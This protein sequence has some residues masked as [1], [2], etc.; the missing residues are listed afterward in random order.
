MGKHFLSL[1]LILETFSRRN[2][3][4]TSLLAAKSHM[5]TFHEQFFHFPSIVSTNSLTIVYTT[6]VCNVYFKEVKR[7]LKIIV[8]E[9]QQ[10]L[11]SKDSFTVSNISNK[12][13]VI[14]NSVR[15]RARN[16]YLEHP[17]Y[18]FCPFP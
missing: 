12:G 3:I 2:R 18:S 10:L 17:V 4:I 8:A 5:S 11:N 6:N 7:C 13:L 1:H 15:W 16:L 14:T 9:R